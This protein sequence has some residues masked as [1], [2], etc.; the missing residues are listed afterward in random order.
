MLYTL[1][2]LY[3]VISAMST[4]QLDVVELLVLELLQRLHGFSM[5]RERH[6]LQRLLLGV[7]TDVG[8]H[9]HTDSIRYACVY[10]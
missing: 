7:H 3:V 10:I 9:L 8:L 1:V 5:Q 4:Y 2:G 6:T